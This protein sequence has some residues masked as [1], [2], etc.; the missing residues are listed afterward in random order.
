MRTTRRL[1]P[2]DDARLHTEAPKVTDDPLA[3]SPW[4]RPDTVARFTAS[5]PNATLVQFAGTELG[6]T[7]RRRALDLGC[8][9]GRN[10]LPLAALGWN[11]LGLDLSW[12][13]LQA[14]GHRALEHQL[15]DRCKVALASVDRAASSRRGV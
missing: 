1:V 3:G 2:H 12:P 10:A 8:G 6:R 13:M 5:E 14:A 11:V 15:D 7:A 9:A 4:S